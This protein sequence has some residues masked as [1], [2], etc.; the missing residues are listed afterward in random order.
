MDKIVVILGTFGLIF[1]GIVLVAITMATY[2]AQ[3]TQFKCAT[4]PDTCP[5]TSTK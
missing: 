2:D 3:Q 5:I 1:T 4:Y